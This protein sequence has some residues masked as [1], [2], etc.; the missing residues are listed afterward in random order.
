MSLSHRLQGVSV[1][2]QAA[3]SASFAGAAD[4]LGLTR[5]AVAKSV[6]RLEDRLQVRLFNRTTRRLRLSDEGEIFYQSC[7]RALA[8]LEEG[9]AVLTSRQR[10]PSGRLR[11]DLP[12][13]FGRR[14]VVPILLELATRYPD[15]VFDISFSDR[16][17]DLIEDGVDLAVRTGEPGDQA[18]L[19][20]RRLATQRSVICASPDYLEAHGRPGSLNDLEKHECIAYGGAVRAAPWSFVGKDGKLILRAVGRRLYFH[21][22]EAVLDAALAGRGL[23]QL[24]TWLAADHLKTG[25]LQAVLTAFSG[26]DFPINA[27]WPQT[28]H[29]PP[30][31]RVVVDELARRFLPVAPWDES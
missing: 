19:V 27:L 10:E 22:C 26:E 3:E 15:L 5:S 6:A 7:V 16:R 9:E 20:A 21:H 12:V 11:V 28:R 14:W 8:E 1:F 4:R 30:K 25:A 2:V 17:I 23:A 29:L 31:V 13:S 18:G 24:S